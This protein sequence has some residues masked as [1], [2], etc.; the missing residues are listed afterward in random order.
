M[1]LLYSED[2]AQLYRDKESSTFFGIAMSGD[3]D[4]DLRHLEDAV[5]PLFVVGGEK[6]PKHDSFMPLT[7]AHIAACQ[8]RGIRVWDALLDKLVKKYPWLLFALADKELQVMEEYRH[9]D[10]EEK[11]EEG[12]GE[13]DRR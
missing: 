10:T 11:G 6:A 2:T 5:M 9:Q 1:L 8:R 13:D 7:L 12:E 4:P 3:L